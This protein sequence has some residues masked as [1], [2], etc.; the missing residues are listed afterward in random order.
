MRGGWAASWAWL[1]VA[2]GGWERWKG[3]R[4][5]QRGFVG[6]GAVE[7]TSSR[8]AAL[9]D[10]GAPC[11]HAPSWKATRRLGV[12]IYKVAKLYEEKKNVRAIYQASDSLAARCLHDGRGVGVQK[13]QDAPLVAHISEGRR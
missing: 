5:A 11:S 4:S 3:P 13:A 1:R 6:E 10:R 7:E 9:V 12:L 2:L 8:V